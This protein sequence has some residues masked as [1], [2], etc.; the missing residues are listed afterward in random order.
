MET[1]MV[2]ALNGNITIVCNPEAAPKAEITWKKD[3]G[4]LA[5]GDTGRIHKLSNGN[6]FL[7]NLNYGDSG[8]YICVATNELGKAES[9]GTLEVKTQISIVRSPKTVTETMINVTAFLPC[10]ASY[11]PHLDLIYIWKL[12]GIDIDL[13]TDN[14]YK[15]E[16][17]TLITGLYISRPQFKHEGIYECVAKTPLSQL[18]AKGQLTVIGPPGEPS[19]VFGQAGTVT[20]HSIRIFWFPGAEHGRG[21]D[22]Y[23][24]EAEIE[25]D[26][27]NWET[28]SGSI[29]QLTTKVDGDT[30]DMRTYVVEGLKPGNGY[31]FRV[32][33][34]NELG[35]SVPSLPSD[36]YQTLSK[37]PVV[38]PANVRGGGGKV[39]D[40]TMVWDK[41]P[42]YDHG[43]SGLGYVLYWREYKEKTMD[44]KWEYKKFDDWET[45]EYVTLVGI[46]NFYLQYEVKVQAFND[47]GR[48]P[49]SSVSLVYSA[50][51]MPLGVPANLYCDAYNAT[52]MVVTWEPVPDTR[53]VM[54]GRVRGYQ[55]N[56][57]Y[58]E[59]EDPIYKQ[60]IRYS[61][62]LSEAIV[63]GLFDDSN[64]WFEVQVFNSAGLGPLSQ[65]FIQE[66][67]HLEPQ[68]YPQEVKV[69]SHGPNSV[70]L[71]WRGISTA[72]VEAVITGYK[73]YLWPANEH[74]R[75]A[76]VIETEKF[77][78]DFVVDGIEGG[79]VY[80]VRIAGFSDGG[81]GK[82][83]PTVYFTLGGH[84][85][86]I[87]WAVS[88]IRA[89]TSGLMY[90]Y[91]LLFTTVL[92]VMLM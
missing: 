87:D 41:L 46:D 73:I 55:I 3:R 16:V 74:Y 53:E 92:L 35:Y 58:S 18:T 29:P 12:N 90:S 57:W 64:F 10:Q 14:S 56:Y 6:L 26:K 8:V 44:G 42:K 5:V 43:G 51:G 47:F 17:S 81:D 36:Y 68:L 65:R 70:R 82:K 71:T 89:G 52:A 2:G 72:V 88:E 15:M 33:A 37:E 80:A 7:S 25:Y 22:F 24:I 23:M 31:R 20:H 67:L 62:Q 60:Y 32:T 86:Q 1:K 78:T 63:I 79:K 48:G 61:G 91:I 30:R 4:N 83:S 27:G 13:E 54:K 76:R 28:K 21:V 49:N 40:L 75:L 45:E 85:I 50:E 59:D 66:T 38:A 11:D 34:V 69:H 19:G 39:G 9:Y 84:S 77:E